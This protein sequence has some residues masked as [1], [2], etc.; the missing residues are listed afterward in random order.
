MWRLTKRCYC[1]GKPLCQIRQG[2]YTIWHQ[3]LRRWNQAA[4]SGE[5]SGLRCTAFPEKGLLQRQQ[6]PSSAYSIPWMERDGL[7]KSENF[8]ACGW[9]WLVC[10]ICSWLKPTISKTCDIKFSTWW[11]PCQQSPSQISFND[12]STL[13]NVVSLYDCFYSSWYGSLLAF[14][15]IAAGKVQLWKRVT[16][17]CQLKHQIVKNLSHTAALAHQFFLWR[18]EYHCK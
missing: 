5:K 12:A 6:L 1:P 10:N 18:S 8:A 13:A 4:V 7:W 3:A 9:C 2:Q 16:Y 17:T 15:Q 11:E 14:K